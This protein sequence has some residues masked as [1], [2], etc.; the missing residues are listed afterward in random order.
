MDIA[1]RT[2]LCNRVNVPAARVVLAP[3]SDLAT[4]NLWLA[5]DCPED[6]EDCDDLDVAWKDVLSRYTGDGDYAL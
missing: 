3:D 5:T 2:A 4:L 6:H 1:L